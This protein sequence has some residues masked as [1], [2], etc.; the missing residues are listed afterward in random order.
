MSHTHAL[1]AAADGSA[2]IASQD[3]FR[4]L[5]VDDDPAY[6]FL[7]ARAFETGSDI[8][9]STLH[10][11]SAEEALDVLDVEPVDCALVD[12]N[13]PD[14][15]GAELM[16]KIRARL[17]AWQCP[18][19]LMT[20]GGSEE[21]ATEALRS[22]AADYLPKQ[23]ASPAA[24]RRAVSHAV[25]KSRLQRAVFERNRDLETANAELEKRND[26]IARF[27]HR[28]SHELKTPLAAARLLL[29]MLHEGY[30]GT[31][32]EE[33]HELVAQVIE[34]CGEINLQFDDLVE[35]TRLEADKVALRLACQPLEPVVDRCFVALGGSANAGGVE[36]LKDLA[37]DLPDLAI[38][39]A[40]IGQVLA[41]LVGN[42]IRFTPSGGRVTVTARRMPDGPSMARLEV[43]DTGIGISAEHLPRLFD[44]LYQVG[45]VGESADAVGLGLGLSIAKELVELHGGTIEVKS[46]PGEGS[47]FTVMLPLEEAH[48]ATK[49]VQGR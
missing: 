18:M 21:I 8:A 46:V 25:D 14:A 47:C 44:R 5:V 43:T 12:F 1:S 31:L 34:R 28:V 7:C 48:G 2:P 16:E 27:Y 32:S 30:A 37:P 26:E 15:D 23:A 9:F 19:I 33:Q 24:L 35:C 39:G 29:S 4:V 36:L 38:D 17:P 20:A 49:G 13:L 45:E 6:R 11:G 40:R 42:A 22:G 41:N 3:V 10:A